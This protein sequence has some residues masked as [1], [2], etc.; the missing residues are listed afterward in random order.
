MVESLLSRRGCGRSCA[1][2]KTEIYLHFRQEGTR[3]LENEG[4]LLHIEKLPLLPNMFYNGAWFNSPFVLY[5]HLSI[6][7]KIL[8]TKLD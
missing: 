2:F 5:L 4:F 1:S 8:E 3:N 7:D 6:N